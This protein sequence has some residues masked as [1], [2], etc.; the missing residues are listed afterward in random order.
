MGIGIGELIV[1]LVIC[2]VPTLAIA[3]GLAFY[4]MSAGKKKRASLAAC[5]L[6]RS[7]IDRSSSVC[8]ACGR[9]LPPGWAQP[10]G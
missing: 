1:I 8:R 3:G 4:A 6:C 2:A 5:P 10:N 9:D 7:S